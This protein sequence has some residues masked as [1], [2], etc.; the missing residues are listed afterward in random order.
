MCI[1]F[2]HLSEKEDENISAYKCCKSFIY[3][4]HLWKDTKETT[5]L[6]NLGWMGDLVFIVLLC[7][8]SLIRKLSGVK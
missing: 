5:K 6:W 8:V 7:V 3:I 2:L 4:E 1:V